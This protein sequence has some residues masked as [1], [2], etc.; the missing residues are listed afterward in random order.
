MKY[1]LMLLLLLFTVSSC[2]KQK[3]EK[4]AKED[5]EIIQNYIEV[6]NLNA[7]ATGSG[8]YYVILEPGTGAPCNSNSEVKVSYKGYFTSGTVFDGSPAAGIEFGLQNVI[9]GW[10]E[11]IPYFKEGGNGILLI[12]SALGYGKKASGSIPKNSVLIFDVALLE[13]L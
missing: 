4:Q 7:I 1:V 6:H 13:V 8:L 10:T 5:D 3:A 11:G 9:S 12:P 2:S